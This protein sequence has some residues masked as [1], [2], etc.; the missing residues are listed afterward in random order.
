[1]LWTGARAAS[2]LSGSQPLS[3][4]MCLRLTDAW[5][6]PLYL[7]GMHFRALPTPPRRGRSSDQAL[8]T[9]LLTARPVPWPLAMA[10]SMHSSWEG[11]GARERHHAH[12]EREQP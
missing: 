8:S 1:M 2:E 10:P 9:W 12:R 4:Q 5:Q 6:L 7:P 3:S 11:A